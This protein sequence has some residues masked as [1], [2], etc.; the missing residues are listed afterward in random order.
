M[1]GGVPIE[2]GDNGE[3]LGPNRE[4]TGKSLGFGGG[5]VLNPMYV[6]VQ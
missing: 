4:V 2:G 3:W 1:S 5:G 6:E